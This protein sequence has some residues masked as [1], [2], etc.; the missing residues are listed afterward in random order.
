MGM[1]KYYVIRNKET[2]FYFRGK[3]ANR[4]GKYHNQASVYRMKA[5]AENTL[6]WLLRH[7]EPVEIVPI[8][9]V[10]NPKDT[11]VPSWIPVS[12][13]LPKFGQEVIAYSDCV[14]FC[15]FWHNDNYSWSKVTHWMPLPEPPKEE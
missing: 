5:H 6:G 9:I 14:H 11:N 3:G 8:Q 7:G 15:W 2:G 1:D 12:E 4:W 10:E 13:R